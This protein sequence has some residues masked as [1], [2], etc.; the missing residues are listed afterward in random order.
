MHLEY[1]TIKKKYIHI[2]IRLYA[3]IITQ[4]Q[5]LTNI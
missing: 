2:Y 4:L 1:I 5:T 3:H